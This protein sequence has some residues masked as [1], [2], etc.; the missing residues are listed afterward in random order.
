MTDAGGKAVAEQGRPTSF[1]G[2]DPK[3]A[4]L[5]GSVKWCLIVFLADDLLSL[6]NFDPLLTTLSPDSESSQDGRK[7][8]T[9]EPSTP[10]LRGKEESFIQLS[11]PCQLVPRFKHE[12][13]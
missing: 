7:E 12:R 8:S 11:H 1:D 5:L 4:A 2:I 10:R 6:L 13:S 3:T 9:F